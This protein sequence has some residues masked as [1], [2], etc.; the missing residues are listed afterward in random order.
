MTEKIGKFL[1]SFRGYIPLP[2]FAAAFL[3]A[4]PHPAAF[5][6]GLAIAFAGETLRLWAL[7]YIGPK[8]RAERKTRASRLIREGP[9]S[10]VRNPLY[11]ANMTMI[12]GVLAASNRPS[13]F[14]LAPVLVVYYMLVAG[15]ETA[16]LR[17]A[18]PAEAE[19]YI[20]EVRAFIPAIRLPAPG[21]ER[22]PMSECFFPEINTIAA[23][24]A[25]FFI[26]G[27]KMFFSMPVLLDFS[28][29]FLR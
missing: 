9:Y 1:Y 15:A 17:Q 4:D 26:I 12:A 27:L 13:L 8:S 24:E 21:Q 6:A 10:I 3:A 5:L 16:F 18:F 11:V 28:D 29:R 14:A 20:R 22:F 2:V 19:S 25:C 7:T 23:A